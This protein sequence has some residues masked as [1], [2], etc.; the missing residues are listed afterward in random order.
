MLPL[1]I[2]NEE[3]VAIEHVILDFNG[4]LAADG[5][6]ISGVVPR[7]EALSSLVT[8]HVITADTNASARSELAS[9]PCTLK[10]I[11]RDKQDQAKLEYARSLGLGKVLAIGNGRNDGL[12]LKNAAM[13]ICLIQQEGA[14]VASMLAAEIVCVDIKDALD[15]L[16]Q[17][18]R[19]VATMR[20]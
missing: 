18:H 5:K 17:P 4:T 1:A 16:L 9:L 15:L 12:L 2:P 19:L 3:V 11:G 13:G 6:L 7:V 10:I 8:V 14:A 20:N